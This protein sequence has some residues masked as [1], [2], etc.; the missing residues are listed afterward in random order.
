MERE[1]LFLLKK[2]INVSKESDI[3]HLYYENYS[4]EKQ[5]HVILSARELLSDIVSIAKKP[6]ESLH[7][8]PIYQA[9]KKADKV[10]YFWDELINSFAFHALN[11]SS[12]HRNW[13]HTS[14]IELALRVMASPGRFDR[15]VLSEAFM[16]FY[17]KAIPGQRG[18]R[19]F[20]N[21]SDPSIGYLFLLMPYTERHGTVI[22]Y[23]D[24]RNNM[25][26]DYALIYGGMH[27][28]L[29]ALIGVAAQTRMSD[30]PL[31]EDFFDEG[32]DYIYMDCEN[33]DEDMKTASE[34][35]RIE[36]ENH[37][38]LV[39]RTKYEGVAHEFPPASE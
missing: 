11:G 1:N 9:K 14:E 7:S 6:I 39:K 10:S 12:L 34:N 19:I 16:D 2:K 24:L 20:Y 31:S 35:L 23:R 38:L 17:Y 21:P 22:S 15:R 27:S 26:Q 13:E 3:I 30:A 5:A 32:Q 37:G 18:T 4:D 36:Y 28:E 25:L 33:W 29:S 8:N